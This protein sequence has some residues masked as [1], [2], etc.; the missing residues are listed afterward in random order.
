[1]VFILHTIV[2]F[3]KRYA[4]FMFNKRVFIRPRHSVCVCGVSSTVERTLTRIA[5]GQNRN[6]LLRNF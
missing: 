2:F 4:I 6:Y 3:N 1:M 5:R